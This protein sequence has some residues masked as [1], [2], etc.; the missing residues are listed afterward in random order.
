MFLN[1]FTNILLPQKMFP[2][3]RAME[4]FRETMFPQ[5]FSLVCGRLQSTSPQSEHP[6]LNNFCSLNVM[7]VP[8][9]ETSYS[10]FFYY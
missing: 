7:R 1:L 2:R 4:T 3:L 8:S 10:Y 5:Q 9:T 6:H